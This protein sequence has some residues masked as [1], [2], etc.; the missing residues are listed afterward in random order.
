[1]N[2]KNQLTPQTK[3]TIISLLEYK[4]TSHINLRKMK[5]EIDAMTK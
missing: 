3:E 4:F 5:C 1:M 2:S